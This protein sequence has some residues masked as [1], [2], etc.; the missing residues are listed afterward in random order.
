M[1][2]IILYYN[3]LLYCII[4]LYIISWYYIVLYDNEFPIILF[5]RIDNNIVL[6]NI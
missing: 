6:H 4:I 3:I 2:F 1:S 5:I